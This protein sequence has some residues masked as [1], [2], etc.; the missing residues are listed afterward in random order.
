[1]L[2]F[3]L[4]QQFGS[5]A[6]GLHF[7]FTCY[8]NNE[9]CAKHK[10]NLTIADEF[11]SSNFNDNNFIINYDK[12]KYEIERVD[13]LNTIKTEEESYVYKPKTDKPVINGIDSLTFTPNESLN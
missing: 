12:N 2:K 7:N 9:N 4:A 3:S 1:M 6:R 5:I 11:L 8:Q 13:T 10:T